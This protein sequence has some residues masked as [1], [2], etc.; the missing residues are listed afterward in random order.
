MEHGPPPTPGWVKLLAVAFVL[1]VAAVV[2]LHL[3]GIGMGGHG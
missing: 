3:F 1:G 2:G